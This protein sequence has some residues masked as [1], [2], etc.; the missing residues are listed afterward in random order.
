MQGKIYD[1]AEAQPVPVNRL[2]QRCTTV[3]VLNLMGHELF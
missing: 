2:C 1:T 3:Q